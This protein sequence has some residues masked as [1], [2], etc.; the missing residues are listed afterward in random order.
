MTTAELITAPGV[1]AIAV[2]R[3]RGPNAAEYVDRCFQPRGSKAITGERANAIRYGSW[4]STGE[5]LVVVR[6]R[7]NEVE[8]HCHG[9]VAAP[10]SVLAALAQHGVAT[11]DPPA[12]KPTPSFEAQPAGSLE[13]HAA[14]LLREAPTGRV[15]GVLLDQANGALRSELRSILAMIDAETSDDAIAAIQG[16]LRH[17]RLVGRLTRPWRVVLAGPPNVGKS[18]LVN[19]LVGYA[20]AIVFDQPGTTRDVVT[21]TTAIDG[22]PVEIADTAGIRPTSANLEQAGIELARREIAAA[23]VVV[24]VREAGEPSMSPAGLLP[25]IA[26]SVVRVANKQDL[27]PNAGTEAD[28]I[29]TCALKGDGIAD[30]LAAIGAAL[31]LDPPTP[32]EAVPFL[33]EQLS[34]LDTARNAL[35]QRRPAAARPPLQ[36]LLR[37]SDSAD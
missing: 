27:A 21:A 36:A 2:V 32:G 16:L 1:A 28:E 8:V 35:M 31:P 29:L 18:S 37:G 13:T 9:G 19:S 7:D 30:L 10:R 11:I 4:R 26:A 25:P 24:L 5:E 22:W 12:A 33:A 17:R 3:V 14:A 6:T 34:E 23:D 20:R 15:A